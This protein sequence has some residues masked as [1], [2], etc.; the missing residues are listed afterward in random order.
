MNSSLTLRQV[1]AYVGFHFLLSKIGIMSTLT[2]PAVREKTE[3]G[4]WQT[5]VTVHFQDAPFVTYATRSQEPARFLPIL[6]LYE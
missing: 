3:P 4:G 6:H 5:S 2:S 1:G